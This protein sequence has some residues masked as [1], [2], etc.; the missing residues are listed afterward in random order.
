MAG[1][2]NRGSRTH[3]TGTVY[4]GHVA[5]AVD[6]VRSYFTCELTTVFR[7]GSPQTWPV[8]AVL[9][10]DA[11]LVLSTS[12][13]YPQKAINIRRN[14]KVS[15]LFSEPQGSGLQESGA[16]LVCGD[17]T[18]ED[19]VLGDMAATPELAIAMRTIFERQPA[20]RFLRSRIG[21]RLFPTYYL[22]LLIS[23]TP[24]KVFYWPTRDFDLAPYLL[25][26]KEFKDVAAGR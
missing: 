13:S 8:S 22:R 6:I 10:D 15:M 14:S 20:S 24:V 4:A 26:L 23:V 25:D 19:A 21:R 7:D 11:R 17:A 18:A 5:D 1:S 9:L 16:V 12:I 3:L 2:G